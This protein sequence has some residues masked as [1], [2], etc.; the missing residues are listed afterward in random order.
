MQTF[1]YQFLIYNNIFTNICNLNLPGVRSTND[2]LL[3]R[4]VP[5]GWQL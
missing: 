5:H 2:E 1:L 3:H 4:G